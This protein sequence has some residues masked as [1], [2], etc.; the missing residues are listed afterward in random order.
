MFKLK[1]NVLV[2]VNRCWD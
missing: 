2:Q 1:Y